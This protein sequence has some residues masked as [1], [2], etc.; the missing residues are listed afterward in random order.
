MNKVRL[1]TGLV[2]AALI[3]IIMVHVTLASSNQDSLMT[4]ETTNAKESAL[5]IGKNGS[6][7]TTLSLS[8]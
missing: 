7:N 4:L 1:V 8:R 3:I 5:I 2:I 6:Q